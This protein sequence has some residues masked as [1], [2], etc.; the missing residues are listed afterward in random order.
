MLWVIESFT[1]LISSSKTHT[2]EAVFS[3]FSLIVVK[4]IDSH[5]RLT[6]RQHHFVPSVS[7]SLIHERD[8]SVR[9][10]C[11]RQILTHCK[12]D[13]SWTKNMNQLMEL[14]NKD[15]C[16]FLSLW[17]K[18]SYLVCYE[19]LN[20]SLSWFLQKHNCSALPP[21]LSFIVVKRLTHMLNDRQ[22]PFIQFR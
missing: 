4:K 18:K 5:A 8:V 10:V 16:I 21:P 20:H 11:W 17:I 13:A 7:R 2:T 14:H 6:D 15:L 19:S 12:R 3:T 9:L 22:C 1:E